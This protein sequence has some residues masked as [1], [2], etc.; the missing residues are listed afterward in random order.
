MGPAERAELL[1]ERSIPVGL[2]R[3]VALG[4]AVLANQPA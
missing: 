1:A 3:L 2:H 4:A